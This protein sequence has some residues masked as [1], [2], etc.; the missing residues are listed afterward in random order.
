M[1]PARIVHLLTALEIHMS[2]TSP[3]FKLGRSVNNIS[4]VLHHSICTLYY[5]IIGLVPGS[6]EFNTSVCIYNQMM[7]DLANLQMF[8]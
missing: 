3:T 2:K 1:D 8:L 5:Q 7:S 4:V 6:V